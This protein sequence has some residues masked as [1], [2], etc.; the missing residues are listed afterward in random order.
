MNESHGTTVLQHL[1]SGAFVANATGSF[2]T[3]GQRFAYNTTDDTLY[4][5]PDGSGGVYDEHAVATLVDHASLSAGA[6]GNLFFIA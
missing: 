2:T 3:S 4:Y 5:D 6:A 1:D